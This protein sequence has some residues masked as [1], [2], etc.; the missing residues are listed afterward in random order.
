ME[1]PYG[2]NILKFIFTE[3]TTP[4]K[5]KLG[6]NISYMVLCKL[7]GF[8]CVD[9]NLKK[10]T[11]WGNGEKKSTEIKDLIECKLY[12]NNHWIL[13]F[14]ILIFMR[15]GIDDCHRKLINYWNINFF[16]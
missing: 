6:M 2:K 3:T 5:R 13:P 15:N 8:F 11:Q 16:I 1:G 9:Q 10:I 7:S 12:M 14:K 4:F